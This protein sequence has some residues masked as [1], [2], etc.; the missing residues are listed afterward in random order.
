MFDVLLSTQEF[1]LNYFFIATHG[2][3]LFPDLVKKGN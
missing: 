2:A 3:N 1:G